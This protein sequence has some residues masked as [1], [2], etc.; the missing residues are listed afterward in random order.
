MIPKWFDRA[1]AVVAIITALI[2]LFSII[3]FIVTCVK[4]GGIPF[5]G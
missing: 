1:Q 5:G 2:I 3:Y 4:E